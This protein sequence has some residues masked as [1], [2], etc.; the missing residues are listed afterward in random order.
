LPQAQRAKAVKNQ[1]GVSIRE[2][3]RV[4]KASRTKKFLT[5]NLKEAA[6]KNSRSLAVWALGAAAAAVLWLGLAGTVANAANKENNMGEAFAKIKALAGN[7]EG[8][9]SR[10]K[11]SSSYEVISNGSAVVE[12]VRVPG[13][14]EMLTVYHL[15]GS[16]LVLTHYCTAGNQP[17]MQAEAYDPASNQLVFNFAGGG[18]LSNLNVGHMHNAVLKFGG[19]DDFSA[20]WTFQ[21]NGKA[22]FVENIEYH[23]V[24]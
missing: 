17:H 14:D 19:A 8:S 15:D 22:K 3:P 13:E 21:E 11:V 20:Q 5:G 4:V 16:H 9:G 7:W 12:H 18:N 2:G 6:M 23:R 1:A 24:K 10:G